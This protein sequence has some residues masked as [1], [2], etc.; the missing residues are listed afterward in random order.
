MR[1]RESWDLYWPFA[2]ASVAV[3]VLVW[4]VWAEL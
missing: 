4:V 2:Y 3:A 1:L